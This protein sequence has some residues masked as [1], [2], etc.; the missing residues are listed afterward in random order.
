MYQDNIL[1]C[2][3]HD[4]AAIISDLSWNT[5]YHFTVRAVDDWQNLSDPVTLDV[6]VAGPPAG[7]VFLSD[8]EWVSASSEKPE[9]NKEHPATDKEGMPTRDHNIAGRPLTLA[10]TVFQPTIA[11][12]PHLSPFSKGL[13]ICKT[14]TITYSLKTQY[15][16]FV[17]TIGYDYQTGEQ[18]GGAAVFSVSADGMQKYQSSVIDGNAVSIPLDID[19]TDV[20][21]LTLTV[22]NS[23]RGFLNNMDW[24]N[25]MVLKN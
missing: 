4:N 22:T 25:A 2:Y 21:T 16:R 1:K 7:G 18:G 8:L 13:C 14:G 20:D 24:A 12:V 23:R 9:P 6:A 10:D 17:C 3:T 11:H 15:K 5:H 19:I